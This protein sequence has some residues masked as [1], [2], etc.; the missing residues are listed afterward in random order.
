M[1]TL[2]ANEVRPL[3]AAELEQARIKWSVRYVGETVRDNNWACD[4]WRVS[5]STYPQGFGQSD[6]H[7]KRHVMETDYYTGL[8]LRKAPPKPSIPYKPGTIAHE[9]WMK[10][11]KP[12]APSA[13]DV[14]HSLLLDAEAAGDSFGDWCANFGYNTDSIKALNTYMA[15]AKIGEE[16]RKIMSPALRKRLSELLQDY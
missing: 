4:A 11:A 14:L 16:L 8:G 10:A 7:P 6:T 5:L 3:V 12:Q 13:A 1:E 9:E 2:T 15:C